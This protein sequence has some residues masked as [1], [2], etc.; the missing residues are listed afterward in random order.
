M[1]W[2]NASFQYAGFSLGALAGGFTVAHASPGVV[3]WVGGSFEVLALLLVF[4]IERRRQARG[5]VV[6][7]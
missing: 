4:V 1:L 5:L 6:A 7:A 3:G 2:L